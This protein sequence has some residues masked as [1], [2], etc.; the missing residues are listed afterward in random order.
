MIARLPLP[1]ATLS[2]RP[3]LWILLFIALVLLLFLAA[4]VFVRVKLGLGNP[5]LFFAD[6]EL[7]YAYV[8]NQRTRRFGNWITINRWHMRAPDFADTKASDDELR[9]IV[10]G[11]SVIFGGQH[12][13]DADV[14]SAIAG[15]LLQQRTGRPTVVGNA[16]AGSWGPPN[17]LAF[18]RRFGTLSADAVVIVLSSHDAEDVI[19]KWFPVGRSPSY[20]DRKPR[21]ALMELAARKVPRLMDHSPP[22]TPGVVRPADDDAIP[23]FRQLL[24]LLRERGVP[25]VFFL[26]WEQRELKANQADPGMQRLIDASRDEGIEPISLRPIFEAN[27]AGY[28]DNIHPSATGQHLLGQA[29]ADA[30]AATLNQ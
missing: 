19:G 25:T 20:P 2:I 27:P 30:V 29:I 13:D 10:L 4:E 16:S 21:I 26:H 14:C 24:A 15:R 8:A 17:L 1:P 11:D 3:L 6:S 18:V 22:P 5:T 28:R 7:E 9:V 12:V 23:D